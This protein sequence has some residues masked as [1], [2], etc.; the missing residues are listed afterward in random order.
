[1]FQNILLNGNLNYISGNQK[2]D[3]EKISEANHLKHLKDRHH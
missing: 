3:E 1:M 2:H